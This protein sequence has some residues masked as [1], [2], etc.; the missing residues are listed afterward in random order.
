VQVYQCIRCGK[1]EEAVDAAE[2]HALALPTL[3]HVANNLRSWLV[4]WSS[5]R[6]L[7]EASAAALQQQLDSILQGG[8]L[9]KQ[10]ATL[11]R[12]V[13]VILGVLCGSQSALVRAVQGEVPSL[14]HGALPSLEDWLWFQCSLACNATP[15]GL[16][17]LI[18]TRH[19]P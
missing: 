3:Q 19:C 11:A 1:L 13:L 7:P 12:S 9:K 6:S 18:L 15:A 5:Q 8:E 14:V 17:F 16:P 2:P 4:Q 10:S